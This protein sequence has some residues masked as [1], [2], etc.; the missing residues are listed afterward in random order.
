MDEL[1]KK[2]DIT[3]FWKKASLVKELEGDIDD[4]LDFCGIEAVQEKHE[5][6]TA[7]IVKLAKDTESILKRNRK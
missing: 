6:L 1:N 7:N 5:Q 2:L 4:L 3:N